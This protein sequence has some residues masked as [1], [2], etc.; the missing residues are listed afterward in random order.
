MLPVGNGTTDTHLIGRA[1]VPI[2]VLGILWPLRIGYG[3]HGE[4]AGK[5][6]AVVVCAGGRLLVCTADNGQAGRPVASYACAPDAILGWVPGI[7]VFGALACSFVA[8]KPVRGETAARERGREECNGRN[9]VGA[10]E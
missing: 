5:V 3:G 9:E 1:L 10:N 4:S 2:G 6:V 7:R 8:E